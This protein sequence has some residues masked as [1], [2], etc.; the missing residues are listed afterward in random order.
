MEEKPDHASPQPDESDMPEPAM[1]RLQD[2]IADIALADLEHL[3]PTRKWFA[4]GMAA[5]QE[6]DNLSTTAPLPALYS[7]GDALHTRPFSPTVIIFSAG[8]TA[9]IILGVVLFFV[10]RG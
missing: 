5:E 6:L 4:E 8:I 2:S 7:Q 3:N 10:L 9:T 1:Q